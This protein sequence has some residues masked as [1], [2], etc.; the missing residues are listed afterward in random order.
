MTFDQSDLNPQ[1]R[2]YLDI[3]RG[4]KDQATITLPRHTME[5][6]IYQFGI[7]NFSFDEEEEQ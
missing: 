1:K 5:T 2:S 7:K 3:A 6:L 4:T